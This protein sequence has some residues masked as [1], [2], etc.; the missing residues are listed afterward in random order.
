MQPRKFRREVLIEVDAEFL[1]DLV[2]TNDGV[3]KQARDQGAPQAVIFTELVSAHRSA[4]APVDGFR[5]AGQLAIILAVSGTNRTD[6]ANA[7][8]VEIGAGLCRITLEIAV[9]CAP[10]LS[11]RQFIARFGEM[12]HADVLIA[13][14]K[15]FLDGRAEYPEFL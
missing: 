15:E 10:F 8:S 2:L 7:H 14:V 12:V 11:H 6:R 4:A 3:A 9:Q 1:A 5:V 13:R